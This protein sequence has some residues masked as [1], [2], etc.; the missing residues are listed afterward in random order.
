MSNDSDTTC[1]QRVVSILP[2]NSPVNTILSG[3]YQHLKPSNIKSGVG[4]ASMSIRVSNALSASGSM[5]NISV[6]NTP[7][8]TSDAAKFSQL[9]A[10]NSWW[11]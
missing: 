7:V 3:S 6:E 10:L 5:E 2:G 1:V 4:K 11:A 9:P 8:A